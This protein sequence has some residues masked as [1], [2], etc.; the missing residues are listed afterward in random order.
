MGLQFFLP[1]PGLPAQRI[2][3]GQIDT[4]TPQVR[5]Y[6]ALGGILGRVPDRARPIDPLYV[7]NLRIRRAL[8]GA[9][10]G[11]GGIEKSLAAEFSKH[12]ATLT[13][14]PTSCQQLVLSVAD[15]EATPTMQRAP[16]AP[17]VALPPSIPK[18]A[19]DVAGTH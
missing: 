1:A 18:R 3:C 8:E 4:T 15:D 9:A 6:R 19:S 5:F 7:V 16:T 2:H 13:A 12:L 17:A 14:T 10:F 11:T